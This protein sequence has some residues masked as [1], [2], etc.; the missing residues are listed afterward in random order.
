MNGLFS[1]RAYKLVTNTSLLLAMLV[2]TA[3]T[4]APSHD[5]EQPLQVE[6][7]RFEAY[8]SENISVFKD[9]VLIVKGSIRIKAQEARLQVVDGEVKQA[10]IIGNPVEFEQRDDAGKLIRGWAERIEYD[11]DN[12]IVDLTG[13]AKLLHGND[14]FE[15]ETIHYDTLNQRVHAQSAE[16]S[17]QRVQITFMPRNKQKPIG[18]SEKKDPQTEDA[19]ENGDGSTPDTP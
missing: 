18:P 7:G 19:E 14:V 9:D 5:S 13:N 10:T 11:A 16:A 4:P 3:A 12:N 1:I 8:K 15:S 17:E 2:P 6:A